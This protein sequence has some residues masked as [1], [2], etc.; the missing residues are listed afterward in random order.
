MG[1]LFLKLLLAAMLVG[2]SVAATDEKPKVALCPSAGGEEEEREEEHIAQM[3]E[4]VHSEAQGDREV[5]RHFDGLAAEL[6]AAFFKE[7]SLSGEEM[8]NIARA[9]QFATEK[10]KGQQRKNKGKTPYISHPLGVTYN[11]MHYGEVRDEALIIAALLHDVLNQKACSSG[12]LEKAFGK[13]VAGYIKEVTDEKSPSRA[14]LRRAQL[15]KAPNISE[16]AAQI[17]LADHLYNVS[18]LLDHPPETWSQGRIDRYYQ[19]IQVLI[20]RLPASNEKLKTA[21]Q[22]TIDRYWQQQTKHGAEDR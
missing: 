21:V 14:A 1:Q 8:S 13:K 22:E 15:I 12:E 18:D 9:L 10:H 5:L 19:W 17:K 3:R 16:G 2:T 7:K 11:L 6:N 20:E 4:H